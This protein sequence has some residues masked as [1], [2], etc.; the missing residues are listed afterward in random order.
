[1]ANEKTPSPGAGPSA[2]QDTPGVT[3]TPAAKSVPKAKPPAL[4]DKPFTEF[5]QQDL[6]PSLTT[7]LKEKGAADIQLSFNKRP[8]SVFGVADADPYWQIQG[9]CKAG[10]REF[11]VVFTKDNINGP[12]LFYH[13]DR[14]SQPSTIEQF[15]GDERKVTLDLMVAFLLKRLNGQKWLARN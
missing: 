11:N 12:K 10:S 6:L 8:L 2:E 14:G 7:A 13:C 1:M 4:E 5:I 3:S 15:M 9:V